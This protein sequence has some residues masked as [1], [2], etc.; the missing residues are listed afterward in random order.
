MKLSL[1]AL[2]LGFVLDLIFGDPRRLPHPVRFIGLLIE[3]TEGFFRPRCADEAA[4]RR[5]GV[6]TVLVVL[7]VSTFVPLGILAAAGLFSPWLRLAL[8]TFMCFQILAAKSLKSESMKVYTQLKRGDLPAARAA[9][10]MIVGRDTAA[11]S[12]TGVAKAAVETVAENTSDGVIAPLL[13]LALG[14]A[15]LGFFYKAVNTMD[16]MLGYKNERYLHFGRCAAL[17]DDV[18]NYIPAR[19]SAAFM[20]AAAFLLRCD[21]RGAFKIYRRDRHCHASPNSA[22]TESV[23]AGALGIQLAGDAYYFGELHHKP[24]IGDPLR[25]AR[26]DDIPA[27]NRLMLCAAALALG[28]CAALG[29]LLLYF[30]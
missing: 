23:C 1:L 19:V 25:E 22:Q 4:L 24:T 20:L 21:W 6:C 14:G 13:F 26:Y 9:V 18:V 15:P 27:A 29:A 10:A 28:A 17:L 30:L 2:C 3:K 7:A 5:G 12:E 8:E 16:S 11:L